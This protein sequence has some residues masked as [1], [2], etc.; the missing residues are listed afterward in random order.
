MKKFAFFYVFLLLIT[1][2]FTPNRKPEKYYQNKF[3]EIMKGRTELVLEDRTRVD[4]LTDS[5][6]IEV[7][8]AYK[9]AESIG[10]SLYYAEMT[11]KKAG[12]LLLIDKRNDE[13]HIQKLMKLATK[14][15]IKVWIM[16]CGSESWGSVDVEKGKII[17]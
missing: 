3:A 2:S 16:D 8:F 17:Y 12:V 13:K 9:W 14:Y 5:F 15:N 10:Q 11:G 6:A 4:I 7:D 1:V